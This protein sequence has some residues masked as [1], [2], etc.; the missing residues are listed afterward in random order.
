MTEE[1]N[2]LR[3]LLK[4]RAKLHASRS[5]R[6]NVVLTEIDE[7]A[8]DRVLREAFPS[9]IVFVCR[10]VE[11][12]MRWQ[13]GPDLSSFGPGERCGFLP[14]DGWK[15]SDCL[16]DDGRKLA[17]LPDAYFAYYS[18]SLHPWPHGVGKF[19]SADR[20][21]GGIYATYDPLDT[22]HVRFV[23]KVWRLMHKVTTN[24]VKRVDRDNG[25]LVYHSATGCWCGFDALRWCLEDPTRVLDQSCQ[26]TDDWEMPD[27]PYYD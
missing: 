17:P 16:D 19:P 13:F 4:P 22:V 18:S 14:L 6:R 2:A 21:P 3:S 5:K 23:R 24:K 15:V 9:L 12:E 10:D 1:E 25:E 26:P 20:S 11:G 8:F 27:S 7:R